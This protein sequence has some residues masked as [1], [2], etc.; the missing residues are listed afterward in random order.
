MLVDSHCHLTDERFDPDRFHVLGRA[1]MAGVERILSIASNRR[2]AEKLAEFLI[3]EGKGDQN[4]P[5]IWGTAGVH[6][7][8]A[9]DA[10]KGDMDALRALAAAHSRIVAVGET[11][12]DFHYDHSPRVVQET[13]FRE[14][15][16]LAEELGLPVVVHSRS[17]DEL[18][19]RILREDGRRVQ[20]VLH[21][22]T[23]GPDLLRTALEVGWM[24]SFTGIVTFKNYGDQEL[25]RKVPRDRLMVETDAPYLAPVPHRGHRNEPAFVFRVAEAVASM[26][27]ENLEDVQEYT[28]ANAIRFFSLNP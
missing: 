10:Q 24:V 22:F 19:A 9:E 15:L 11:G 12:L 16:E 18:T 27:E 23:G 26:R 3:N 2:D 5:R 20:G 14:H 17:A 1:R 4:L 28:S 7:H 13:L 6:P 25:V 8:E 21:C